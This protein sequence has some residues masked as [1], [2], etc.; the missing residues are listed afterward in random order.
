MSISRQNV[1]LAVLFL[2]TVLVPC[3]V[4]VALAVRGMNQERELAA[5][6]AADLKVAKFDEVRRMAASYLTSISFREAHTRLKDRHGRVSRGS[7]E[8]IVRFLGEIR[9]ERLVTPSKCGDAS[10]VERSDFQLGKNGRL[11][12]DREFRLGDLNGAAAAWRAEIESAHSPND[13]GTA[14]LGLA[15]VLAKRGDSGTASAVYGQVLSLPLD[16]TDEHGIPLAV[17]AAAAVSRVRGSRPSA[18]VDSIITKADC[19]SLESL[20]MLRGAAATTEAA[21]DGVVRLNGL[22]RNGEQAAA[23]RNQF[24]SLR[25][26]DPRPD[27]REAQSGKWFA[28]GTP[29]WLVGIVTVDTDSM[30]IAFDA[31]AVVDSLNMKLDA[32]GVSNVRFALVSPRDTAVRSLSPDIAGLGVRFSGSWNSQEGTT[33]RR[34]YVGALA[35]V[36]GVALLA[37]RCCGWTSG[38]SGGSAKCAR[39]SWRVYRMN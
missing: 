14:R 33:A 39:T 25:L 5:K 9:G 34:L 17:Y 37:L 7:V 10:R 13:V 11:A 31:T 3:A 28:F 23:L 20:Y 30:L 15:R 19:L 26:L 29:P 38:A 16:V 18:A 36:L 35:L 12:E 24:A 8:D 1:R 32:T 6:H 4:L 2:A 22:I 21:K 27:E